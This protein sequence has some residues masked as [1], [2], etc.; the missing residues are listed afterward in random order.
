MNAASFERQVRIRSGQT[1][2]PVAIDDTVTRLEEHALDLGLDFIRVDPIITRNNRTLTLDVEFRIV[3]GQRI[4][5]ERIDIEGNATTLDR[6]VRRQFTTVEGDPFNP[7]SIRASAERIRALGFFSTADVNARSGSSADQVVIDVD[8]VEQPTGTLTFGAAYSNESGVGL[9]LS[10]NERNFLGRGQRLTFEVATGDEDQTFNFEFEEPAFLDRDVSFEFNAFGTTTDFENLAYD[11]E[12]IGLGASL[13]FPIGD[14]SRLSVGFEVAQESMSV[15]ADASAILLAED[16]DL[17]RSSVGYT[18]SYNN[19]RGAVR[20]ETVIDLRFGQEFAGL[21]GDVQYIKTTAR[22]RAARDILND[23]VTLSATL[24]GG[25]LS[26]LGDEPSRAVDRFFTSSQT[27]RGFDSRGIGPRDTDSVNGDALGGNMYVTARLQADFPLGLPEEI[28]LTGAVFID[29]G[30]VWG[31][32]NTD[33]D[34]GPGSVDDG[35]E[36]RS[37]AGIAFLLDTPF[38]PFQ[39]NFAQPISSNPNDIERNFSISISTQ[40]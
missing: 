19:A 39:F 36:L 10:F 8:L 4:F 22:A 24:Q 14:L 6:V 35:F 40:F 17:L 28:G 11:T 32:D 18:Y 37:A 9:L 38:G 15:D 31:L 27:L 3:R 16:G 7:R 1:F 30:S 23:E 13:T 20:P 34:G 29:A 25:M 2:S 26:M 5:V 12:E 33:G 21:G